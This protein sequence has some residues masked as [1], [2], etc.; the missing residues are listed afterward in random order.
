MKQLTEMLL[1]LSVTLVLSG[2]GGHAVVARDGTA[3][4]GNVTTGDIKGEVT[5]PK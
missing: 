4:G 1:I 2:C 5:L 3:T